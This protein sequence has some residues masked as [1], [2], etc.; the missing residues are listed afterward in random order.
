LPSP[1]VCAN[2]GDAISASAAVAKSIFMKISSAVSFAGV[3]WPV[4]IAV[5]RK[6]SGSPD[7]V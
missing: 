4:A 7:L 2:A 1:L 3:A 6:A 5:P